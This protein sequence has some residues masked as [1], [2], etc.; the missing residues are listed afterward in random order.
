MIEDDQSRFILATSVPKFPSSICIHAMHW[1]AVDNHA[2][3]L[4]VAG[5]GVTGPGGLPSSLAGLYEDCWLSDSPRPFV[6]E[7]R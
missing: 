5:T 2:K 7:D 1:H 4:H 3:I 6:K